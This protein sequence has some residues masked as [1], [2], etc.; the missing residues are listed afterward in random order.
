MF[1]GVTA[2]RAIMAKKNHN[3]ELLRE[4][5]LTRLEKKGWSRYRLAQELAGYIPASTVYAWLAGDCRINDDKASII[6][7][8]LK[9]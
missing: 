4:R 6:L 1:A 3:P 8:A 2:G 5:V 7:Q 9:L